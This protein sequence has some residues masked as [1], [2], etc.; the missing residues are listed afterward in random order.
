MNERL[1]S[2][3]CGTDLTCLILATDVTGVESTERVKIS[4]TA[5]QVQDLKPQGESGAAHSVTYVHVP[6]VGTE[7]GKFVL[8]ERDQP[9]EDG[10]KIRLIR[11]S[12]QYQCRMRILTVVSGLYES[13]GRE[14]RKCYQSIIILS[15]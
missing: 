12:G 5:Q 13:D 7:P 2:H 10:T 8:Q 14:V 1:K 4:L 15:N 11:E 9:L 3:T 6:G